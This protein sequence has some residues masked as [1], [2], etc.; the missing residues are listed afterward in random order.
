MQKI[1]IAKSEKEKTAAYGCRLS[2]KSNTEKTP[3]INETDRLY[4]VQRGDVLFCSEIAATP[5]IPDV[6]TEIK[7][8]TFI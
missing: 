1:L 8:A 5:E 2:V 7:Y 3:R 6:I 4:F